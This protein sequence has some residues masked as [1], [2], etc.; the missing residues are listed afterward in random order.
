MNLYAGGFEEE[1][2]NHFFR[3]TQ[4]LGIDILFVYGRSLDSS[5]A[6]ASAHNSIFERLKSDRV[7]ALIYLSTSLCGNSSIDTLRVYIQRFNGRPQVSIG[8]GHLDVPSI[9]VDGHK[10]IGQLVEHLIVIHERKRIAFIGG[11]PGAPEA[12]AR[13]SA[14]LETLEKHHLPQF[15][16]FLIHGY[17][18]R[19]RAKL[20]MLELLERKL[21]LDAVV[22]ANDTMAFGA[23]DALR[24]RNLLVPQQILV[25]GFDDVLTARTCNPPLTTV[26]QPFLE[27]TLSSIQLVVNQLLKEPVPELTELEAPITFRHSC[28]CCDAPTVMNGTI[29]ETRSTVLTS[30]RELFTSVALVD[31]IAPILDGL[32]DPKETAMQLVVALKNELQFN[33]GSFLTT[34]RH[35]IDGSP[36]DGMRILALQTT[37]SRLRRELLSITSIQL[38]NMWH[39]ARDILSV[40]A[41]AGHVERTLELHAVTVALQSS[42]DRLADAL[43]LPSL[44][45]SIAYSLRTLSCYNA[46]ITRFDASKP[47]IPI[48]LVDLCNGDL[49]D[50]SAPSHPGYELFAPNF[51]AKHVYAGVL[52]P[53]TFEGRIHGVA[54]FSYLPQIR[55]YQLLRDQISAALR[56]VTKHEN[57][58]AQT[59]AHE[60]ITHEREAT[61]KRLDALSVL[62]GS[63]AHD[64]NNALG[65][66][67]LLLEMIV[68]EIKRVPVEHF[69]SLPTVLDD[70]E[71]ISQSIRQSAQIVLDLLTLGRQGR[72]PKHVFDFTQLTK[73]VTES[74]STVLQR[75]NGPL[76][77]I[78]YDFPP[79]S[80]FVRGAEVQLSRVLTNLI[81]NAIDASTSGGSITIALEPIIVNEP[82]HSYETILP[83]HYARI[84]VTDRGCGIEASHL[85]RIFEPYFS[86]KIANDQS[87]TGLGLAI[88]HSVVKDHD[89][90]IDV[91]SSIGV[92]SVFRLYL[93][94]AQPK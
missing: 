11:P 10:A 14:Y 85:N 32:S 18:A 79:E 67:G 94:L 75:R 41:S 87:G 77:V 72:A 24:S 62:A 15:P 58:L 84:S 83:G 3:T 35:I 33:D 78:L 6:E 48:P 38:E 81:R 25:T 30:Q 47:E 86:K 63:I 22:C 52:F 28:G 66:V 54:A 36:G 4:S 26:T 73:R 70:A 2:R 61:S 80:L 44:T 45:D 57:L 9:I 1:V 8:L 16:E 64:L 13:L 91:E 60:R 55:G 46:R 27:L 69:P 71:T 49:I 39:D 53:L 37:I 40:A 34:L 50:T 7:D 23:Y 51:N 92:G 20:A 56:N 93:P 68:S 19:D 89:G 59:R 21:D 43:D 31:A 76:T 88:V 12:E 82:L 74:E 65:P 90:F 17:F 42:N 5:S 29:N